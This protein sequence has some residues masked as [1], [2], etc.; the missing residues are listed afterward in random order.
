MIKWLFSWFLS[1]SAGKSPPTSKLD[2]KLSGQ[3]IDRALLDELR[4]FKLEPDNKSHSNGFYNIE[5]KSAYD[6][7]HTPMFDELRKYMISRVENIKETLLSAKGEQILSL[8]LYGKALKMP[9]FHLI[10]QAQIW[11]TKE[12]ERKEQKPRDPVRSMVDE[13]PNRT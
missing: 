12:N 5:P 8:Q 4:F 9:I 7:V 2:D 6:F 1:P 3:G 11:V 13:P 10:D